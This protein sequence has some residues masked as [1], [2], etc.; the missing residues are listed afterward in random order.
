MCLPHFSFYVQLLEIIQIKFLKFAYFRMTGVYSRLTSASFLRNFFEIGSLEVKINL[1]YFVLLY[2]IINGVTNDP[3]IL[4][5][6]YFRVPTFY[7]ENVHYFFLVF[8]ARLNFGIH[9]VNSMTRFYRPY[10]YIF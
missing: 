7:R 3:K 9:P 5:C 4:A 2:K 10:R 1:T 6:F 8:L